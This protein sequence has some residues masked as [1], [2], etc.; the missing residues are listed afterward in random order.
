MKV[1][2]YINPQTNI[3]CCALLPEAIPNNVKVIELE[4]ET[5]D[6]V[7]YI[8]GVI[9]VK[10]TE[11]KLQE[12]KQK[13]IQ[14]LYQKA[15][16]Y[17]FRYYD[18][19]KLRT[20]LINK[21]VGENYL[22]YKGIDTNAFRKDVSAII[23][24]NTDYQTAVNNL[25]QKYNQSG[26]AMITFWIN[27]LTAIAYRHYFAYLVSQEYTSYVQQIQQASSLPLPNF[28][29]KTPYPQLT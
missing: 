10:T 18:D 22:V 5:P 3:L 13:A 28:E 4:V 21:E 2:A 23:L 24:S 11:E 15:Y 27:T 12:A 29:F 25:N 9:R 16:E 20:D 7:V 26:D 14:S 17:V 19:R 8:D 1:W 6:D